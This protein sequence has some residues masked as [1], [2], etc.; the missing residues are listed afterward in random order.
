LL[1]A[2]GAFILRRA[3]RED[4]FGVLQPARRVGFRLAAGEQA[5]E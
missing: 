5:L 4:G 1:L 2:L 3:K